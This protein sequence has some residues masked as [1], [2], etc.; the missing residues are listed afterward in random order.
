ML[1]DGLIISE[2]AFFNFFL[3]LFFFLKKIRI[4][5]VAE[6]SLLCPTNEILNKVGRVTTKKKQIVLFFVSI[7][8][9]TCLQNLYYTYEKTQK[10]SAETCVYILDLKEN[11]KC[12]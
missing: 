12:L 4:V 5:S 8:P 6:T 3:V 11:Q 7:S 10:S 9:L 1:S 2:T